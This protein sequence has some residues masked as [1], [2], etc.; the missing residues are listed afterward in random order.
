[1]IYV[2]SIAGEETMIIPI[3]QIEPTTR[4]NLKCT[5]CTKKE[6]VRDLEM[7]TLKDLL[8]KHSDIKIVKL[9]GLGEPFMTPR[10]TELCKYV[11]SQDRY[12]TVTTN[13]TVINWDACHYIDKV[14]F[15]IDSL[16]AD[17]YG[18]TRPT[19]CLD[20]VLH[21]LHGVREITGVGINQ[22]ITAN[23]T[24]DEIADVEQMCRTFGLTHTT[25][26]LENW[27][28]WED[29]FVYAERVVN[30]SQPPRAPTCQWCKSSFYYDAH[31]RLHP[32][33]IR[34]NDQ[35]IIND[36]DA[37][38]LGRENSAVCGRCPD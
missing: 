9:Q 28:V 25:P 27:N 17:V 26:R 24:K 38:V 2:M 22:V 19:A 4:C 37:F 20:E 35:Y 29:A 23:T 10:F 16:N 34:M 15:S 36:I 5:Y 32:C 30:G 13:G 14:M 21:N 8:A 6:P 18:I 12:L 7:V 11:K 31:G 1:M 3:L 33:C